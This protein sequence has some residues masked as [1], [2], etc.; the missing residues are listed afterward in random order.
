MGEYR[1][2]DSAI[3][4][5][6][7]EACESRQVRIIQQTLGP[8]RK[9]SGREERRGSHGRGPI[10]ASWPETPVSEANTSGNDTAATLRVPV[11]SRAV[12]GGNGG[13]R[14]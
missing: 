5:P 13:T 11:R 2:P 7:S 14:G 10:E 8:A 9:P 3:T 12:P 4:N 6:R 1:F